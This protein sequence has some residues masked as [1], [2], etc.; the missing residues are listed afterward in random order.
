MYKL[1][2]DETRAHQELVPLTHLAA[3]CSGV[4]PLELVTV[5]SAPCCEDQ[6][7][8]TTIT[9]CLRYGVVEGK[10]VFS[11]NLLLSTCQISV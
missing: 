8:Q 5:T 10:A 2:W 11:G 1:S 4:S 9:L 6:N 7:N 3:L